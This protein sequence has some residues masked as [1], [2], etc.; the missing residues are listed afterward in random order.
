MTLRKAWQVEAGDQVVERDGALLEVEAV[1]ID[2]DIVTLSFAYTGMVR[3]SPRVIAS[4]RL[5][6]VVLAKSSE[7]RNFFSRSS[8][9]A[10]YFLRRKH[11]VIRRSPRS[12]SWHR[13]CS[14]DQS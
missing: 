5:V 4:E 11:T 6:R 7:V 8:A 14:R 13:P 12:S 1:A 2:G 9:G 10:R 3:V